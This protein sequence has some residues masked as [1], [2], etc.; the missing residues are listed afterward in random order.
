MNLWGVGGGRHDLVHSNILRIELPTLLQMKFVPFG[1]NLE[2]FYNLF[3]VLPQAKSL[4]HGSGAEGGTM[5]HLPVC[6]AP[7]L[8]AAYSVERVS[9][10]SFF[11]LV[12]PV[13]ESP[14]HKPEQGYQ[15]S[16]MLSRVSPKVGS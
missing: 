7:S 12:S 5:S 14:S 13:M 10:L 6:N 11:W 4:S 15:W 8:G 9:S 1:R 2:L 3:P 16:S